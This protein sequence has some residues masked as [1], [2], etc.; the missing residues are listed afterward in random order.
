VIATESGSAGAAPI[1]AL[2][3]PMVA[4]GCLRIETELAVGHAPPGPSA[5]AGHLMAKIAAYGQTR[6]QA[7][8]TLDR[9]LAESV[10]APLTTNLDLL[11]S[12]LADEAFRAG[13]YDSGSQARLQAELK[14]HS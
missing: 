7:L 6:H 1:T 8:L 14:P 12:I 10:I 5:D 11:R 9:V 3:W 4:P 13:Q 2:R